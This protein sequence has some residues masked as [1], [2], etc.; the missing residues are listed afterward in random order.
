MQG[1]ADVDEQELG[2]LVNSIFETGQPVVYESC[3]EYGEKIKSFLSVNELMTDISSLYTKG[4]KFLNYGIYY[5][6]SKGY[7][8]EE[9][10]KLNPEN[11][12]GHTFRYCINGWGIIRFQCDFI[13]SSPNVSCKISVNTKKRA[14]NWFSTCPNFKIPSLWDWA[15]VEKHARR[16]IRN[17]KKI[18]K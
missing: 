11:C 15:I 5:P 17:A 12:N 1:S 16:L 9:K 10:I 3:S 2:G 7:I 8:E 13:K 6:E 14:E 18:A 4:I